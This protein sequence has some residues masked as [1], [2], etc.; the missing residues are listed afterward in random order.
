[1]KNTTIIIVYF[2]K[3]IKNLSSQKFIFLCQNLS[4]SNEENTTV[5]FRMFFNCPFEIGHFVEPVL[6][7]ILVFW[8]DYEAFG[9]ARIRVAH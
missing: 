6:L 9:E 4:Q 5:I 2:N 7:D 3:S 8:R 1:M